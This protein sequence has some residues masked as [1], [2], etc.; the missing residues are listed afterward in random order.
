MSPLLLFDFSLQIALS[1]FYG[2]EN[3]IIM[4]PHL[5]PSKIQLICDMA[6]CGMSISKTADAAECSKQAVKY[7]RSNLRVFG[8]PRAPLAQGG[9][10]RLITPVMLEA[11]CEHL[12]EK[13]G[14]YLNEM[15]V[16]LWD[17]F[18]LEITISTISR[19]LSSIG[20]SK[21]TIQQKAKEQN[22]DLR[23]EYIHDIQWEVP[24]A[25]HSKT[26]TFVFQP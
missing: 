21:K 3:N 18:N 23:D 22:P 11:L 19:A 16:F 20:W 12:L 26:Y 1:C 15:A 25:S 24:S 10:A 13:P 8:S 7:I 5:S 2:T 4:A 9:R 6:S 14:L 17:E